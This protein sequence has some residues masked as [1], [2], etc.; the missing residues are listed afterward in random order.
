MDDMH[1]TSSHKHPRLTAVV[2]VGLL[3]SCLSISGTAPVRAAETQAPLSPSPL[4]FSVDETAAS[5]AVQDERSGRTWRSTPADFAEDTLAQGVNKM[6]LQSQIYVRFMTA[7]GTF[8]TVNSY[9]ASTKRKSTSVTYDEA[10][11]LFTFDFTRETEKFRIPVRYAIEGDSL[12]A[13][14][15]GAKVEEYGTSRILDI[16][17]LPFFGAPGPGSEGYVLLPD[18]SG[19]LMPLHGGTPSSVPYEEDVFGQNLSIGMTVKSGV[20]QTIQLPVFGLRTDGGGF[21]ASIE[22]A[23]AESSL[24]ASPSGITTLHAQVHAIFHLRSREMVTLL[25]KNFS[26]RKVVMMTPE[27][28]KVKFSVRYRFLP[29]ETAD[30]S[31]MAASY[32]KQLETEGLLGEKVRSKEYP[33][34]LEMVGAV[35]KQMNFLGIPYRGRLPLS[36]FQ[37][38]ADTVAALKDAGVD[39][40][41]LR[42]TGWNSGGLYSRI[43]ARYAPER[44]LGGRS[45][46][47]SL[48][49]GMQSLGVPLFLDAD[50]SGFYRNGNGYGTNR[51]SARTIGRLPA[52]V[53]TFNPATY[54]RD[55][56]RPIRTLLDPERIDRVVERLLGS[57][58][59]GLPVGLGIVSYGNALYSDFRRGV[60]HSSTDTAEQYATALKRTEDR[61]LLVDGGNLY[62][63]AQADFVARAPDHA[64]GFDIAT[65]E[66]P[67]FFMVLHGT[68][69]YSIGPMNYATDPD[70]YLL[71]LLETGASPSVFWVTRTDSDLTDTAADFLYASAIEG[72]REDAVRIYRRASAILAPMAGEPILH[73]ERLANGLVKV[74]YG[75][76]DTIVLNYGAMPVS[77]GPD[78]IP[79]CDFRVFRKGE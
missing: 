68:I 52:T 46:M 4:R 58:P 6:I 35:E 55:D 8:S 36:T 41:A 2:A 76:G 24:F 9:T 65:E 64:S 34:L 38:V 59:A 19:A 37:D 15:D 16:G 32:R 3:L 30:Y 5:F 51:S 45:G 70:R 18:G 20:R 75:N 31:G 79:A 66:V 49:E 17:L 77:E 54:T 44:V 63:L 42:L 14:I 71:R 25:E 47:A 43:D 22:G 74:L 11:A 78:I 12:V 69:P 27:R 40:V 60:F 56:A 73:H 57:L 13:E 48:A 26:A 39:H 72:S 67:F 33:L 21:V 53:P 7:E 10:G 62:A 23:P 28:K 29:D 50:V 61:A 1:R